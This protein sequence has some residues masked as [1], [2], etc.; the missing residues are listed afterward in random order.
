MYALRPP[1]FTTSFVSPVSRSPRMKSIFLLPHHFA[2]VDDE[3]YEFVKAV[4]HWSYS[5]GYACHWYTD[6]FGKRRRLWMHRTV[7]ERMLGHEIPKGMQV[8][9]INGALLGKKARLQNMR[10][11]L[12]LASR[13]EQQANK[14]DQ[15]NTKVSKGLTLRA[16]RYDVRI[17]Y[18]GRRLYLGRY[19]DIK[20][21]M[22]IYGFAHRFLWGEFTTETN[23]PEPAEELK[24]YVLSRL[25]RLG[26]E[27]IGS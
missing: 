8:D 19:S 4:G 9:H 24:T 1:R 26:V 10:S 18:C 12:R 13:S 5:A 14:G 22:E 3:D 27:G 21:A 23:V 7:M 15:I 2:L 25:K 20:T 17:R 11:N 6:A 16:G